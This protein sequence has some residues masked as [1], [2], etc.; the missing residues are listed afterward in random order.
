MTSPEEEM[1]LAEQ[2][3]EAQFGADFFAVVQGK[4]TFLAASLANAIISMG[5]VGV[6]REDHLWSYQNGV[7]KR[8]KNVVTH[9][10]T[11]F[12]GERYRG[13]QATTAEDIIKASAPHITCN[14]VSRYINF[15][16]TMV[17][18]KTGEEVGHD[19]GI[20][21]TIQLGANWNPEA[22]CPE[23][24][25]FLS[26]IVPEDIVPL[27]WEVI[28][29]LM[30]TGNPLHVAI[31]LHGLGR[32][33]KGTLLRVVE[34][35]LGTGNITAVTLQALANED[36]RFAGSALFGKLANI[37]GDIDGTFIDKTAKFKAITGEDVVH[38][39]FKGK[40]GFDFEPY[41]VP[42]FSANKIPGSADV[43]TGYLAR[44]VVLPFPNDFTGREDRGLR[45]RLSAE[46]EGIAVKALPALR[47]LM[48]RGQFR[49][50]ASAKAA[51]ED[52][53]R[54][55]D[56]V[57]T[58]LD[59]RTERDENAQPVKRAFL[60][61]DYKNWAR[62]DGYG[63]LKSHEFYDRLRANGVELVKIRGIDLVKGIKLTNQALNV[64][65][66]YG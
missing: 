19:P 25:K 60:Y 31:M 50:P 59:D 1:T 21:S 13:F 5:P 23:F 64:T 34:D 28:G 55:V 37:A 17:D 44:W 4:E 12:M 22:T 42:V 15:K 45:E 6:G 46:A 51:K 58:W 40:D 57:S 8:D 3:V 33:G 63:Q 66:P 48:D 54:K 65:S 35:I 7:W 52:F 53:R 2:E 18:W 56:Q 47:E 11:K 26:T 36:N 30:M 61:S 10:A 29:Y 49:E 39:E 9:R 27:V 41:A 32:N 38:A 62:S 24:D 14:P 20:L 16:N 43:S